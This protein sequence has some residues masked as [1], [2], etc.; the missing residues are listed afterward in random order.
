MLLRLIVVHSY[1]PI[2][3]ILSLLFLLHLQRQAVNRRKVSH[4]L[5][6]FPVIFFSS[7]PLVS[8]LI[9]YFLSLS[10]LSS[11]LFHQSI[12]PCVFKPVISPRSSLVRLL[13]SPVRQPCA[14]LFSFLTR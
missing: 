13:D 3:T 6:L 14:L 5:D 9:F 1:S 11:P 10:F 7:Y 4:G 8:C 2:S 12:T